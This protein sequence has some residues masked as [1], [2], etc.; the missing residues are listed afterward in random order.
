MRIL[1]LTHRLPYAPN[2]GDRVRAYHIVKQLAAR[3]DVHVISLTHDRAERAEA[4]T[5]RR[6]GVRVSTAGVPR[7]R[8]LVR[9]AASLMTDTPLTHLLL[10]SP[11]LAALVD[12]A[13]R[14]W[15]PDVLLAYCS[16]IAPAALTPALAG[17]PLVVDLVDVDS[18]KWSAFAAEAAMP[19]RWVFE[20]EARCL[21]AFERLL[22]ETAAATTVVNERERTTLRRLCPNADVQVMPNGVDVDMF[23]PPD[24]PAGDDRVVFTAVFDYAPNADG[25]LWF[26]R[27]VW[28]QVLAA[29]PGARLTL[30]GSSPTRAVRRLAEDDRSIDVTGAVPDIRPYLWR[31]ALAVAPI[32]QSRGVQNKV[33]EAAAA[34]LP[35][36]VTPAVWDGLPPEVLPAVRRAESADQFAAAVI[37]LLSQ[38]AAERRRQAAQARVSDL[39]WP[40]R[41]APLVDLLAS[42]ARPHRPP[43]AHDSAASTASSRFQSVNAFSMTS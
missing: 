6:L 17:I 26:A 24:P 11:E 9:A 32:A 25:A 22:V 3:A 7:L 37:E 35:T 33:L 5:L 42:A 13:T 16:G 38:S 20:R 1:I 41:L 2:R 14:D 10:A 15:R 28:P 8:N 21:G 39:A 34:G 36:V 43:P 12:D 29:R 4:E 27:Q 19:R 23:A 40:T 18:A 31:A 30:A